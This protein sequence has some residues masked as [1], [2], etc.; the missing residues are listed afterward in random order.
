MFLIVPDEKIKSQ[1][2]SIL[3]KHIM[4][5]EKPHR[6]FTDKVVEWLSNLIPDDDENLGKEHPSSVQTPMGTSLAP[7]KAVTI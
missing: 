5:V 3:S 2:N 6:N 1:L 7:Q 4:F